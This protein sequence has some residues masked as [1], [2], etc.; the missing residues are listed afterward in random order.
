MLDIQF[1]QIA[2]AAVLASIGIANAQDSA[3]FDAKSGTW[4]LY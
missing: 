1:K 3:T 4:S 2:M